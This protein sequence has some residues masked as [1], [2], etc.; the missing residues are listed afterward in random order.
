[1]SIHT[2]IKR[3]TIPQITAMKGQQKIVCLTSYSAPFARILDE[4]VDLILIGDSTA[5]VGYQMENTLAI[6]VEQMAAHGAAVM[7]STQR[8]A[9]VV[10]MPFS[11][12]QESKE[13][14]FRNAAYILKNSN[15]QAVKMEG[16]AFLAETTHFLT[17]RGIPVMAHVGLMPQYFN[18]MGG[19]K[20]QGL[21]EKMANKIYNDAI[22]QAQAGAFALVIEGSAEGL[23]R[24][25]TENIDIPTIGIGAS[26]HCDGQILVSE[27][28][29]NLS[30][31][32]IPKFA[33]QYADVAAVIREGAKAYAE[34]VRSESFPSLDHCFGVVKSA[35][36]A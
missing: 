35:N 17:E 34:E 7:R 14:A 31:P 10:D 9:V 5:M 26:P 20:A 13:Q 30:G 25:I 4:F 29:F 33:K 27:D 22:A 23:A 3:I 6:T 11:S 32:K 2:E 1:M 15:V 8:A 28:I 16:G 21:T 19:F 24:R 18:T 36:H 12:Y